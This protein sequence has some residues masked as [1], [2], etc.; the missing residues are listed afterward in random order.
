M[1]VTI[2]SEILERIRRFC[3]SR[4]SGKIVL[5]IKDGEIVSGHDEEYWKMPKPGQ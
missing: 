2:P 4:K 3:A 1:T 5:D